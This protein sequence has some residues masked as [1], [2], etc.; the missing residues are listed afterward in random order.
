[1][2]VVQISR[3]QLRRGQKNTATGIPQLASGEMAWAI[4]AQELYIG[5][6]SV[7]EGSPAVENIRVLTE[8]DNLLDLIGDYQFEKDNTAIQTG[9]DSNHPV[10]TSYQDVLDQFVTAK[11][12]GIAGDNSTDDTVAIQRAIDQL[13]LN[14]ANVG[15]T[16]TRI[17]LRFAPGTYK[18]SSTIYIPSYVYI[19]GHGIQKTIFDY[20]GTGS[21]FEFISD[22]STPSSRVTIDLTD[23]FGVNQPKY[24][25]LRD[26][27]I[28]V[29]ST[30]TGIKLNAVKDSLFE[31]IEVVGTWTS[32]TGD[33]T[34]SNGMA[35]YAFSAI[36]TC[37]RN[38]FKGIVARSVCNG[39]YAMEDI[40]NNN[41][42]DCYFNLNR[43]GVSFG[44]GSSGPGNSGEEYGPR[45]NI[46]Q[47]SKFATIDKHG[48]RIDRGTG[49]KVLSNT[50]IDVGNDSQ[51]TA[52][53]VESIIKFV[54]EG[55]IESDNIFDRTEDL[56]TSFTGLYFTEVD[57]IA[58]HSMLAPK[59]IELT[60]VDPPVQLFRI[61]VNDYTN[62]KIDY[63]YHS[64]VY[65][66]MRRGT[67]FIAVDIPNND[68]QLTEE[69][70][71]N[72]SYLYESN[73]VF[74]AIIS[75]NTVVIYYKNMTLSDTASLSYTYTLL[76]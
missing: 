70:D 49:N 16:R 15:M 61:A 60:T 57:G 46:I 1:M 7:N 67:I 59:S 38:T 33:N 2:A 27:T 23:T 3:I 74:T 24:A 32:V 65:Q 28:K 73:L 75:N 17:E 63:V 20:S 39:I 35:L 55:N 53:G 66:A 26:F 72:G 51:G 43:V 68:I 41:F 29:G 36:V 52:N 9:V 12:F 58:S 18:I 71:Y 19:T 69:Y 10:I 21:A 22:S 4:D 40:L 14:P 44:V 25:R 56:S 76:S 47:N 6:G 34:T 62:V 13:F 37:Q 50:F 45:K 31:N 11:Y 8:K 48:I 5:S 30:V 42:D 54:Q 64:T